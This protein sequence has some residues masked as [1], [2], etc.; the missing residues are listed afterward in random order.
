MHNA[1][2]IPGL[3][4]EGARPFRSQQDETVT[5]TFDV[6][7]AYGIAC[8]P[9]Y[10]IGM[11]ALIVVGDTPENMDAFKTTQMPN[12]ARERFEILLRRLAETK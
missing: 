3:L 10:R 12:R 6:P 7:G 11:I 4:P 2:T 1:E 9:H 5:V 8:A